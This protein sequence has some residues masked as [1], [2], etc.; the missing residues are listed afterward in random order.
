MT[1]HKFLRRKAASIYLHET[2]GL[3]RAPSTLAK[4]AV[5]GGG[6][7]FRR[8]NRIPLYATGDLDLWVE[9]KL[10]APMRSTSDTA[11]Q[12]YKMPDTCQQADPCSA[13][14]QEDS[15]DGGKSTARRRKAVT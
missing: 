14:G 8:I 6:P 11:S 5:I 4:L 15:V 13:V 3:D 7:P 1:P 10:T 2:Y 9:S 12:N